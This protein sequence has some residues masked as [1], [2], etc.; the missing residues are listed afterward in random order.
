MATTQADEEADTPVAVIGAGYVGLIQTVGLAAEGHH[1]TCLDIDEARIAMLR[2]GRPP[3]HEAGLGALLARTLDTGTVRFTTD[4]ADLASA[5]VVF[6]AVGTPTDDRTGGADL[7]FLWSAAASVA[8]HGR[9]GVVLAVKSTVP[10]GTCEWLQRHLDRTAPDKGIHVVS[11]PEF[12]REGR[13]VEDFAAPERIVLGGAHAPAVEAVR[14]VYAPFEA[15]GVP[16]VAGDWS[17]AETIKYAANA[18]LATKITFINEIANLTEVMGGDIETVAR[19]IGL[20][21]RIGDQFLRVGPGYGGSCFPKDSLALATTARRHGVQQQILEAVIAVNDARRFRILQTIRRLAAR[22]LD[23]ARIAILGLAFKAGTDDVRDS[24]ALSL[25]HSLLAEGSD[26][27]AYDPVARYDPE[28]S[29]Y[30]QAAS[31]ED[32]ATD[33]DVIVVLTEW[34]EFAALDLAALGRVVRSRAL[35]DLR[36]VL[37]GRRADLAGWRVAFVGSRM[38]EG[39]EPAAHRPSPA[40]LS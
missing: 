1:V 7:S 36:L 8:A 4:P 35:Y 13:A 40:S 22:P 23:E 26:V 34:P 20:D 29:S 37:R 11:N 17:S 9:D 31:V 25:I 30:V 16:I 33:A 32:A 6:V 24:P 19:G 28:H 15:R 14:A 5:R 27:R 10:I 38:E 2:D 3:I 21:S 12:L 39:A 18:F